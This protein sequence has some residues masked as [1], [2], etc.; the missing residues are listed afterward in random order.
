M[1]L[2]NIV[3]DKDKTK[4]YYFLYTDPCGDIIITCI[5]HD[6]NKKAREFACN[7]INNTLYQ[8]YFKRGETTTLH[9]LQVKKQNAIEIASEIYKRAG[10]KYDNII[11][12]H[13]VNPIL[14][15]SKGTKLPKTYEEKKAEKQK[16]GFKDFF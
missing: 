7:L 11:I 4:D 3:L 5:Q 14:I 16:E 9:L 15:L 8:I 1:E 2:V 10:L 12:T 13:N 6:N